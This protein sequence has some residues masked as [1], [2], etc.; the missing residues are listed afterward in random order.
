MFQGKHAEAAAM[1]SHWRTARRIGLPPCMLRAQLYVVEGKG[2][3]AVSLLHQ[4]MRS[5][6]RA[7]NLSEISPCC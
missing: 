6:R 3:E 4:T 5:S 7:P 2:P 1:L